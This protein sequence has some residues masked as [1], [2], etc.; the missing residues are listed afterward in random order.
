MT[1]KEQ[2]RQQ[3]ATRV[4]EFRA[5]GLTLKA[6]CAAHNCTVDQMKYWLYKSKRTS[7]S[8][9]SATRFIPIT[10]ADD[11]KEHSLVIRVGQAQIELHAGFDPNLLRE[12]VHALTVVRC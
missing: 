11:V 9:A 12:I 3:W 1:E 7:A 8:S 10:V 6:W 2:L 5:S 4:T